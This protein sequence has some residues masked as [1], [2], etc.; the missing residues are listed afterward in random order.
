MKKKIDVRGLILPVILAVFTCVAG[1][2]L[3]LAQEKHTRLTGVTEVKNELRA[4]PLS[5]YDD[6]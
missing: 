5:N 1:A 6:Q 2:D 4:L 3:A